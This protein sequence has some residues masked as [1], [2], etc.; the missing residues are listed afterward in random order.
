MS[1]SSST[2]ETFVIE[3]CVLSYPHLFQP[4]QVN[5]KGDPK[6]S[7]ALLVSPEAA[8]EVYNKA[9]ALAAG[10]FKNGEDKAQ[11]FMWPVV[12]ANTKPRYA[13]NPRL[14]PLYVINAKA[15]ADYPP[16]IVDENRQPIMD[17]GKIYAGCVVAAGIRLYTYNNMGNVGVGVGLSAVMKTGEGEPLG[18][19]SVDAKALFADVQAAPCRTGG[20]LPGGLPAA[21]PS[22]AGPAPANPGMPLPPFMN[23]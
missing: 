13:G 23:Q 16:Q 7:A 10:H 3:G 15:S 5:G 20:P 17:R 6:F 2:S 1:N 14:A 19:G 11:N 22:P 18:D 8:T 9:Q 21:T 4:Q 12:A